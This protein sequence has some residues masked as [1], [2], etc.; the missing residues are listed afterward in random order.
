MHIMLILKN[1]YLIISYLMIFIVAGLSLFMRF[2]SETVCARYR[3]SILMYWG[4]LLM[5]GVWG[6]VLALCEEESFC[7]Y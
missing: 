4:F 1:V 2:R 7:F 3:K 6:S 5:S